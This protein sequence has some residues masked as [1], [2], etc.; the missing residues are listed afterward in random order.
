MSGIVTSGLPSLDDG[1]ENEYDEYSCG[2][3]IETSCCTS[4]P[5]GSVSL[6]VN[7]AFGFY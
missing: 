3:Q 1:D 6:H 2:E 5:P 7:Q 4:L